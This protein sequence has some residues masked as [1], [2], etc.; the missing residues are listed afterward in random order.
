MRRIR[1]LAGAA[2]GAKWARKSKKLAEKSKSD[3]ESIAFRL[4]ARRGAAWVNN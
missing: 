2:S 1:W 3:G 4:L